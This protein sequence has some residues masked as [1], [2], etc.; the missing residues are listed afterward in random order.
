MNIESITLDEW[1]PV[2]LAGDPQTGRLYR[3]RILGTDVD[4]CCDGGGTLHAHVAA[5][6]RPCRTTVRYHTHW[7]SIG[8]PSDEFFAIPEFDEPD[9]RVI[10]LGS[11]RIHVSGLRAIENFL[12]MAHFPFV[13]GGLLGEVPHT[14]VRPY[15]VTVD[16]ERDELLATDCRFYQP[17]AAA[18]ATHGID[19]Q[20][21]YRVVRP[22]A[23]ILYKTCATDQ[24]RRDVICLFAQP[25]DEDWC[26]AHLLLGC[27]DQLHTDSEL[28]LFQQTIVGQDI[29]ILNNH[30]PK[31]LPLD[32]KFETPGR[33]DAISV[34]YRRWLRNKG[35]AYG[36]YRAEFDA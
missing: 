22:L 32:P 5:D 1:Y 14:Q 29:T 27:I 35:V 2:A 19:A 4:Y 21:L 6:G 36:T 26:I 25:L 8:E 33:A 3:T 28:R 11:M 9:R 23:S 24:Q 10:G 34:A 7:I 31:T 16:T 17:L 18:S 12:D 13:H 30:W 20:Y 15:G